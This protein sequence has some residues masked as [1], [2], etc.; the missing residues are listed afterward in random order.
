MDLR[1]VAQANLDLGVLQETK[2]TY[3]VYTRGL[4]VP[5]IVATDTMMQHCGSVAVIYQASPWL[6]VE[7]I[8]KFIPNVVSFHL[9]TGERQWYIVGSYLAP[10]NASMIDSIVAAL[11][12]CPQESELLVA[13][14]FN[15][16][17]VIPEGVEQDEETVADLAKAVL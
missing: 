5:S 16:D 9:V 1:G 8:Q 2:L 3:D 6:L 10:D 15:A 14:Y 13:G 12:D 11:G 7:A 4:V 17:L